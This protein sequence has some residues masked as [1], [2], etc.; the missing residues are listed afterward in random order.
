MHA[1]ALQLPLTDQPHRLPLTDQPHRLL[2]P[3]YT[4]FQ[5]VR[6]RPRRYGLHRHTTCTIHLWPL[7]YDSNL[8]RLSISA[9]ICSLQYLQQ[10]PILLFTPQITK[11]NFVPSKMLNWVN[12][13]SHAHSF[14]SLTPSK[15][16]SN[17]N[18]Q[19]LETQTSKTPT[20]WLA[21]LTSYK[22][23]WQ[24]ANSLLWRSN[25]WAGWW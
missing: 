2:P 9:W 7:K 16:Y 20:G 18:N 10:Y 14:N 3:V 13:R 23:D 11:K 1:S 15:N 8:Q 4:K 6:M 22:E 17:L 19:K 5:N 21:V 12:Q 25:L 24:L